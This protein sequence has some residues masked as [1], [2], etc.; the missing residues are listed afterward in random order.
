[1][2]ST[3]IRINIEQVTMNVQVESDGWNDALDVILERK[4]ER[5]TTLVGEKLPAPGILRCFNRKK[6]NKVHHR[7]TFPERITSLV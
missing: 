6:K 5:V 2:N 3:I 4:R 7:K 1:M